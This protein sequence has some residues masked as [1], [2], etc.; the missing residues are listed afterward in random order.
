ME[1]PKPTDVKAIGSYKAEG[2]YLGW[3]GQPHGHTQEIPTKI[4]P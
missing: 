1:I 4:K 3:N 2:K